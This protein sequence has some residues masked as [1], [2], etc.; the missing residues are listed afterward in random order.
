MGVHIQV[1]DVPDAVFLALKARAAGSGR[2]LSEFLR[3]LLEEAVAAA[4]AP[5]VSPRAAER[6]PAHD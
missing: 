5:V 1:R 6:V 4:P 3:G 2:S